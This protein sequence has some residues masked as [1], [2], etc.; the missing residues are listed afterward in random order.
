MSFT[1]ASILRNINTVRLLMPSTSEVFTAFLTGP[2]NIK[3]ENN[4]Y[5][6]SE[7]IDIG[8]FPTVAINAIFQKVPAFDIPRQFAYKGTKPLNFTIKCCLRLKSSV[9]ED[10]IKPLKTLAGFSLPTRGEDATK[11]TDANS[12]VTKLFEGLKSLASSVVGDKA[13]DYI[14]EIYLLDLPKSQLL[15]NK[16]I[17]TI[18]SYETFRL[19]DVIVRDFDFSFD[20]LILDKG[21]PNQIDFDI[22]IESKRVAT[23]NLFNDLINIGTETLKYKDYDS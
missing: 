13:G 7:G 20:K 23:V 17:L 16:L 12:G 11:I 1:E 19:E 14:K 5:D 2:V 22:S 4:Y 21:F 9:E 18:G 15:E 10:Y 6:I 8:L 3:A